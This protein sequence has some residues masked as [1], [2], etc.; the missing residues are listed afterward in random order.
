MSCSTDFFCGHAKFRVNEIYLNVCK[1]S[2]QLWRS[3]T[4]VK[5]MGTLKHLKLASLTDEQVAGCFKFRH[6]AYVKVILFTAKNFDMQGQ[7]P[8]A[9][10]L[11]IS[12]QFIT[13]TK[14]K[15]YQQIFNTNLNIHN[16]TTFTQGQFF[17]S[18]L[19]THHLNP[20]MLTSEYLWVFSC[21]KKHIE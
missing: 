21:V 9:T 3:C 14:K 16:K 6:T 15:C 17:R 18:Q 8:Y 12:P 5:L 19:K 13:I 11:S 7:H 4:V 2:I 1:T 10:Q 20:S